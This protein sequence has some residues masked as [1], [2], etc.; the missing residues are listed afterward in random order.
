MVEVFCEASE[1]RVR[2][3]EDERRP[4]RRAEVHIL[5]LQSKT[6]QISY[7]RVC[8]VWMGSVCVCEA[9]EL[10]VVC[11]CVCVCVCAHACVTKVNVWV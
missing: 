8:C 5:D 1:R 11:V 2:V 7:A 6:H 4:L 9:K 10:V 3:A